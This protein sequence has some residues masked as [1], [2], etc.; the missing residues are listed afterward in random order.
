MKPSLKPKTILPQPSIAFPEAAGTSVQFAAIDFPNSD[1]SDA[2]QASVDPTKRAK[3][4]PN[5]LGSGRFCHRSLL[6]NPRFS[7]SNQPSPKNVW[8]PS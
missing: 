8:Q 1:D 3:D 7:A 6:G 5:S 2:P 4:R